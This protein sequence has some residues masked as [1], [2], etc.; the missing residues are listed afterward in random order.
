[1]KLADKIRLDRSFTSFI[2]NYYLNDYRERTYWQ[3]SRINL[4]D[5]LGNPE[6][7]IFDF[8]DM[9]DLVWN[10]KLMALKDDIADL[11]LAP[12]YEK[13]WAEI[14]PGPGLRIGGLVTYRDTLPEN[15]WDQ[16][17]GR[18]LIG[19]SPDRGYELAEHFIRIEIYAE[20]EKE[21]RIIIGPL[22][23]SWVCLD[24][25]WHSLGDAL[26]FRK[27]TVRLWEGQDE[28]RRREMAMAERLSESI[29][30]CIDLL[31]CRNIVAKTVR[32]PEALSKKH[33]KKHG[34]GLVRYKILQVRLTRSQAQNLGVGSGREERTVSLHRVRGHRR[35][36]TEDAPLFGRLVGTFFIPQHVRGSQTAGEVVKDYEVKK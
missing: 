36:Y 20:V 31:H 14:A 17:R 32:P 13:M 19:S 5:A 30:K 35:R 18:P 28:R 11:D 15:I 16:L 12:P 3:Q 27:I 33:L 29:C 1:M 34:A 21:S 6:T 8:T 4:R 24:K 22:M 26:E 25:D 10:E 7:A 2:P 9:A 23:A